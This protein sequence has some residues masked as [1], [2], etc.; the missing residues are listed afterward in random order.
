MVD[1][2]A[3]NREKIISLRNLTIALLLLILLGMTS[4]HLDK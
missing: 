1:H 4:T 2:D 3:S